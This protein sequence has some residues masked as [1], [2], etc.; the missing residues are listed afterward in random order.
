MSGGSSGSCPANR[1][2]LPLLYN[3]L[4]GIPKV[5]DQHD[6]TTLATW[7]SVDSRRPSACYLISDSRISWPTGSGWDSGQKLFVSSRF[8]DMFGYCGDVQF[9][10]LALRPIVDRVD[11][12]LLLAAN[13]LAMERNQRIAE[14]LSRAY[15]DYPAH[16][17]EQSTIVH[18][19]RDGEGS[20]ASFS[21]WRLDWSRSSPIQNTRIGLP[22]SSVLGVTLGSGWKI[23]VHRNEEWKEAQGRTARGIFSSFCEAISSGEDPR[24]GGPPQLVGLYPIGAG[25]L[26]GVIIDGKRYLAGN[27]VPEDANVDQF[28]WRNNLFERMDPRTFAASGWSPASAATTNPKETLGCHAADRQLTVWVAWTRLNDR[29]V[30]RQ[31]P[32]SHLAVQVGI[33]SK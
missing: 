29:P 24:S 15:H 10:T 14:E 6:M 28:E 25:R 16:G 12:G 26:F 21:L 17:A 1:W 19:A 23:L 18:F 22:T 3:G 4:D 31:R 9:P 13:A 11:Q 8:P 27:A 2:V 32:Q 5:L 30:T 33:P 20:G 7:V